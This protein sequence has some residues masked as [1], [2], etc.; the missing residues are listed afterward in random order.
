[1]DIQTNF[2]NNPQCVISFWDRPETEFRIKQLGY[3]D[4]SRNKI[5]PQTF[6]QKQNFY[7]I[8]LILSGEGQL[9]YNKKSHELSGGDIFMLPPDEFYAYYPR[10]ANPWAYLFFVVEGSMAK[11]YFQALGL[12]SEQPVKRCQSPKKL[13]P[14]FL[15]ILEKHSNNLP[16][17]YFECSYL[18]FKLFNSIT[19]KDSP[20]FTAQQSDLVNEVKSFIELNYLNPC[21]TIEEIAENLHV[22][23]SWLCSQ[24]KNKT[25]I[26]M[27]SYLNDIRMK[28]AEDL[29]R[30][31]NLKA[32][33]IAYMSGFH[34]YT[35]F[36]LQFKK[37]NNMT[38]TQYRNSFLQ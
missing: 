30:K 22:S 11:E 5:K 27:I 10:T 20:L 38:T 2:L 35:Y 21:F 25:G 7:T 1:M 3:H 31:T 16:V 24:F 13:L 4:F 26:T 36:L 8:H 9:N 28:Y 6:L 17:S 32:T 18:L 33:K 23:H 12:S 29:L 14:D 34:E 37:R 19:D 15:E